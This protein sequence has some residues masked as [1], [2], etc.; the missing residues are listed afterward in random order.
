MSDL[1]LF[2]QTQ[3]PDYIKKVEL[4]D[5]TRDLGGGRG[6]R[7]ISLRGKK[8]R[9]VVNGEEITRSNADHMNVVIING[10]KY[11]AR[12]FYAGAYVPGESLPPDCWSNDGIMPDAS[13]EAPQ[14]HNCQ[15]CPQNIKGSGQ[16]DSRACRFEKRLAV[17]LADDINGSVYQIALPSKS[18]FG[19]S[20]DNKAMPFEQYAKYI[21]SQGYNINQIVT[22]MRMDDNS[23]TAKLVFRPISFLTEQQWEIARRQGQSL[24]AKQAVMITP[25]TIDSDNKTPRLES[26]SAVSSSPSAKSKSSVEAEDVEVISEPTKR[27]PK[28][29]AEPAPKK[30]LASIM[31]DWAVDDDN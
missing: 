18:Y 30:D 29:A 16:G 17:V 24:E 27:A 4:D 2:E 5:L 13:I 19:R 6:L 3:V 9:L 23:D 21:S 26:N 10:T 14:H 1:T 11:V 12:K 8:F 22:E 15:D 31:S 20:A 28:K 7:R 25:S